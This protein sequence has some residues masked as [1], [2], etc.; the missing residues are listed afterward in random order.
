MMTLLGFGALS[1][2]CG[3]LVAY[4]LQLVRTKLQAQVIIGGKGCRRCRYRQAHPATA[5]VALVSLSRSVVFL[6]SRNLVFLFFV[7]PGE[8]FRRQHARPPCPPFCFLP[9]F[10]SFPRFR[11]TFSNRA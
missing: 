5:Q 1:S 3:Q 10:V 11:A 4:P 9:F 2:T 8:G 6:S 7:R